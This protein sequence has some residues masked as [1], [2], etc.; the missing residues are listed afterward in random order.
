MYEYLETF[1]K[2]SKSTEGLLN[3]QY[4]SVDSEEIK[5]AAAELQSSIRPCIEGIQSFVLILEHLLKDCFDALEN[6]ESGWRNKAKISA[7][8]RRV[9]WEQVDIVSSIFFEANALANQE[10]ANLINE[11]KVDWRRKIEKLKTKY[12]LSDKGCQKIS[13]P[14]KINFS[15]EAY[16]LLVSQSREIEAKLTAVLSQLSSEIID[17]K[18]RTIEN[19]FEEID[20]EG[21]NTLRNEL[22]SLLD[23]LGARTSNPYDIRLQDECGSITETW[24]SGVSEIHLNNIAD[25]DKKVLNA[26][27]VRT[28][29]VFNKKHFFIQKELEQIMRFHDGVLKRIDR[30]QNETMAHR[31]SEKVWIAQ[32]RQDLEDVKSKITDSKKD[33]AY[34][35]TGV[36]FVNPIGEDDD[37]LEIKVMRRWITMLHFCL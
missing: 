6:A 31:E 4:H 8:S 18:L 37:S 30:Y 26:I 33:F 28:E 11:C 24:K 22:S 12:S 3:E 25:F 10:K 32:Q 20:E 35:D 9:I 1:R 7:V 19:I 14:N 27:E 2:I 21:K 29:L 13:R 23:R 5:E 17:K 36:S 34:L 16:S 15:N